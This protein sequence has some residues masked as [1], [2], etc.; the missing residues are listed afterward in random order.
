[1]KNYPWFKQYPDGIPHKI[2]AD[3]YSSLADL[4]DR[5][6]KKFANSPAM[7]NMGKVLSYQELE[8]QVNHMASYFQ[9]ETTLEKGD[10]IAIQMPNLLQYPIAMFA[11]LKCGLVVV[12]INPLY[13]ASEMKHQ[14]NDAGAKAILIVENFAFNLEKILSD[15]PIELIITTQ[16]G[17]VLG[18][19]KKTIVNFVVKRIKKMV[20][21]FSLPSTIPFNDAIKLGKQ[22]HFRQIEIDGEDLAFLQYTGGT[23]GVAKGAMLT[24]RNLVANLQQVSGWLEVML[25]EGKEIVITALP[26]YHIFAL[27]SNCFTM[28]KYGAHNV[29]IT[30]PRDMPAF[31]KDMSKHQ[32][33]VITGVNTLFNGLLN[34][35]AF[36]KLDFSKLK[37]AIGGGMA[38]QKAVAEK[39]AT[40]T[41]SFLAEGYG[42]TETSPV[43]TVNPLNGNHRI[44]TIGVPMP[45]TEIKLIA[46]DGTEVGFDEPGE[47]YAKGPQIMK[48]YWNRPE[49]TKH[50]ME[51]E[52]FKSG[53]IATMDSDGFIRIV[54]RK[55]EMILV[56]GF[57]VY[58]NEIEDT[59]AAHPKVLE[60]GAIGVPSKRS[61]EAVKVFI[62]K[63]D[64][65]LTEEEIKTYARENLTAYKC[66][67]HVEF[68]D[69]LP[70]SNVGKILRRI[71]KEND[72]KT[73]TYD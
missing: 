24:H 11:A 5:G 72:A 18:G 67:K 66:P 25:E 17:D 4:L 7:E 39:W 54:D 65:S 62:V 6:F 58:P 22:K 30:N 20:P 37:V 51:G 15:T 3:D 28:F 47:L 69:E 60:V 49:E 63:K 33:T 45:S 64:N 31:I 38:V 50:V 23:T 71:L 35:E 32:F 13:T 10:R 12:N 48:G 57:N 41:G 55:K 53:D 2:D 61:N 1:M 73:N 68:C 16:V 26:L 21:S 29:L 52:W 9:H 43:L 40:V 44:G 19:L 14:I 56:S 46:E 42:L 27:T 8:T 36:A 70:K 34:Q 59:L